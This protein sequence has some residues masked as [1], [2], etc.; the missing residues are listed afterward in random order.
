MVIEVSTAVYKFEVWQTELFLTKFML[1]ALFC[2]RL[3]IV[4]Y[5][6]WIRLFRSIL[7]PRSGDRRY[8][9]SHDPQCGT[10]ITIVFT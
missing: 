4:G 5:R 10:I 6:V 9:L 8:E 3:S 7:R 2:E 1:S